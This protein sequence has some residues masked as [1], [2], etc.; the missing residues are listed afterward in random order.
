M[1]LQFLIL[2]GILGFIFMRM[3]L[4]VDGA[5]I[6]MVII[7]FLLVLTSCIIWF[8]LNVKHSPLIRRKL[9]HEPLN[10]NFRAIPIPIVQHIGPYDNAV[11]FVDILGGDRNVVHNDRATDVH[12]H[13][14]QQHITSGIKALQKWAL[15]KE[16]Q[17]QGDTID[18]IKEYIFNGYDGTYQQKEK[19]YSTL[20]TVMRTNGA[21]GSVSLKELDILE[22]VWNRICDPVNKDVQ[23]ELKSNLL[24]SMADSTIAV[25]T[26][27]C[28]TG[29]ITRIVQSLQSI[30]KEE[31]VNIK[32]T[33][34]VKDEI[35]ERIGSLRE[36]FF[37][38]HPALQKIY[39][40][41]DQENVSTEL[42]NKELKNYVSEQLWSEYVDKDIVTT[43]TF[44]KITQ[45]LLEA[46]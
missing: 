25:D 4:I 3:L 42:V 21:L 9:F 17:P 38:E 35:Q 30:D 8:C 20:K 14:I 13:A 18:N 40:K 12:D 2:P 16:F 7:S 46:L 22:L 10:Y 37:K 44:N 24:E 15:T 23:D 5:H 11:I 39:E 29:R 41:D 33:E 26:P 43:V 34:L 28:L 19:A 36:D 27:Y 45:P 31:I 1:F 6:K 32:S